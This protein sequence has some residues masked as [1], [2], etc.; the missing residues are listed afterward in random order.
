MSFLV[1][2]EC[3]N[4]QIA[5]RWSEIAIWTL[6][7][8]CFGILVGLLIRRRLTMRPIERKMKKFIDIIESDDFRQ[9]VQEIEDAE[10]VTTDPRGDAISRYLIW[11][12]Q[13]S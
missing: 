8:I 12:R 5:L 11:R 2:L 7:G 6:G 3:H 1:G 4:L 9:C 13:R 10:E